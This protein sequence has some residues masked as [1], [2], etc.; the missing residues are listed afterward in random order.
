MPAIEILGWCLMVAAVTWGVTLSRAQ[1][2]FSRSRKAM[3][4]ELEHWQAEAV[5]ACELA[6][7]LKQEIAIWSKGC[8]QGRAD[9]ISILPLLVAAYEQLVADRPV[10]V[11][12]TGY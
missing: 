8:Q 2:A 10:G 11:T 5:R 4:E 7:Q 3:L 9:V 6:A 1:A 12:D